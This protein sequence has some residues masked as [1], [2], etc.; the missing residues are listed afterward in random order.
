MAWWQW[1]LIIWATGVPI[2]ALVNVALLVGSGGYV[3]YWPGIIRNAL[4]WP[5]MLPIVF[6]SILAGR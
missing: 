6:V 2:S 1:S 5:V 3:S 4:L